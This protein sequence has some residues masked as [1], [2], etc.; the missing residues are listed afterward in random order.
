MRVFASLLL[1]AAVGLTSAAA[2]AAPA[3]ATP[4]AEQITVTAVRARAMPPA[5]PNS[6]AFMTLVNAGPATA[7]V[8]AH[9][10]VSKAVELHTHT[11]VDGVMQMRRVPKIPLPTKEEVVL[12]PGGLHIMLIGLVAPLEVGKSFE[13]TLEFEDGSKKTLTVP[14]QEILPPHGH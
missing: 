9:A 13:L 10:K 14:V 6:A 7:L 2:L 3:E 12:K 11:N 4:A 5:A 8:A 1:S